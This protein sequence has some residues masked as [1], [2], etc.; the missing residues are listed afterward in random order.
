MNTHARYFIVFM[1][2]FMSSIN[3]ADRATL[4]IVKTGLSE[5]LKLNPVWMGYLLS[6]WGWSYVIAQLPAGWLL[7]RFGSRRV[8][9]AAIFVW[10]GLVFLMGFTG[11]LKGRLAFAV[12]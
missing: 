3:Y 2:F 10:S 4:S 5:D 6:A 7:D 12:L 9:G 11:F 8:Y 1:L